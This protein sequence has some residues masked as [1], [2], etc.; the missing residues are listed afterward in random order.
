MEQTHTRSEP[1]SPLERR[2]G[3]S[4]GCRNTRLG[5][6]AGAGGPAHRSSRFHFVNSDLPADR[7][8]RLCGCVSDRCISM[9]RGDTHDS[10]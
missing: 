3:R 7:R 4:T 9:M 8:N 10:S 6:P 1:H 2:P 5:I